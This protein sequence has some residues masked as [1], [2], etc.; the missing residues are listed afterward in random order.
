MTWKPALPRYS[1]TMPA[2][3]KSSSSRR[4][5]S[6]TNIDHENDHE[7]G[8][9]VMP[10]CPRTAVECRKPVRNFPALIRIE[11]FGGV[12]DR[13]GDAF[14]RGFRQPDLLGAQ[15]LDCTTIDA[16]CGQERDRLAA[17]S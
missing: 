8:S 13:L 4:M 9:T 1:A 15:P 6:P 7:C 16:G 10:A 12:G 3:R 2:R 14:A 17:R 11:R 5:R